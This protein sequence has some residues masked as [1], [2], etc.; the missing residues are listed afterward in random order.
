[1]LLCLGCISKVP[2]HIS[3]W[4]YFHL[5]LHAVCPWFWVNFV[6]SFNSEGKTYADAQKTCET[7]ALNGFKTG[8]LF[9]PKTQFLADKVYAKSKSIFKLIANHHLVLAWIGIKEIGGSWVYASSGTEIAFKNW[10]HTHE[11]RRPNYCVYSRLVYSTSSDKGK[12]GSLGCKTKMSFIC[13]FV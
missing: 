8:R 1:M 13:E 9:E 4:F 6:H 5:C 12:W 2:Y 11:R 3:P 7:A 10:H